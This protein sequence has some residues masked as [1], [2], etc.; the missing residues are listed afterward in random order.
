MLSGISTV[1]IPTSLVRSE[2]PVTLH[3]PPRTWLHVLIGERTSFRRNRI[4]GRISKKEFGDESETHLLRVQRFQWFV[5]CSFC[6]TGDISSNKS[7][8]HQ[9]SNLRPAVRSHIC[10]L[11]SASRMS[12]AASLK[13]G[14]RCERRSISCITLLM[15][16]SM[17]AGGGRR[18]EREGHIVAPMTRRDCEMM[19]DT[20]RWSVEN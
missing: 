14:A 13:L 18:A 15:M 19:L 9:V 3:C 20:V 16:S 17:V 11:L 8:F 1:E 6:G 4:K 7:W 12:S 2:H 10:R 5:C